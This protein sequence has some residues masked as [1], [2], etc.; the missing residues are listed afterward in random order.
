MAVVPIHYFWNLFTKK[1]K[2]A[3][4]HRI[5]QL[6]FLLWS[7]CQGDHKLLKERIKEFQVRNSEEMT[8]KE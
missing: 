7:V 1:N 6:S 2:H 3:Q 8:E 5:R 4:T